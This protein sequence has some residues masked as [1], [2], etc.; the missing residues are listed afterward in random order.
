MTGR[1]VRSFKIFSVNFNLKKLEAIIILILIPEI[2]LTPSFHI[3]IDC[4]RLHPR[5]VNPTVWLGSLRILKFDFIY[6]FS[7]R[8]G[9]SFQFSSFSFVISL[10]NLFSTHLAL[11]IDQRK[12]TVAQWR[13]VEFRKKIIRWWTR[14]SAIIFVIFR[15]KRLE[16][17]EIERRMRNE[18]Q[19]QIWMK[20][21]FFIYS[22]FR[23]AP[24]PKWVAQEGCRLRCSHN[25][26]D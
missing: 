14:L 20:T 8:S 13:Y 11:D 3:S 1:Q 25:R 17:V 23:S 2:R 12:E 16:R 19:G 21:V 18:R 22:N 6:R 24:R 4:F 26:K 5:S 10:S 15:F 9:L 7:S